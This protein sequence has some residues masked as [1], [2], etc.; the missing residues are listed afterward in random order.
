M[1]PF[2]V[3]L[4]PKR[5]DCESFSRKFSFYLARFLEVLQKVNHSVHVQW[6]G[7]IRQYRSQRRSQKPNILEMGVRK[8]NTMSDPVRDTHGMPEQCQTRLPYEI[9]D[10]ILIFLGKWAR[11]PRLA[12]RVAT[13]L[14]RRHVQKIVFRAMRL[15]SMDSASAEGQIEV[16]SDY[17]ASGRQAQ[18]SAAAMDLASRNGHVDVL[19]WWFASGLNL[20]WSID[21]MNYASLYGHVNVLDWWKASG[22]NVKWT[23]K[24]VDWASAGGHVM[25]LEWWKESGFEMKWTEAAMNAAS[26]K[27]HVDVLEWWKNSGLELKW[28]ERAI[29]GATAAGLLKVLE[30]W[31]TSGLP[32][33]WSDGTIKVANAHPDQRVRKWWK[34]NMIQMK[35]RRRI[36][37]FRKITGI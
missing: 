3:A 31:R 12:F 22:L 10:R 20:E 11:E 36:A 34:S 32:L 28:D 8:N 9:I 30:W 35:M 15:P 29:N 27:N 37:S 18:Y 16:L 17:L 6:N 21:A 19:R 25:V 14:G 33:W 1:W 7:P 4:H 5:N 23:E 13:V 24:A 26:W 2:M